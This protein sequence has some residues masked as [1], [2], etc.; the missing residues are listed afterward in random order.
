MKKAISWFE[1]KKKKVMK[2]YF[3]SLTNTYD[4]QG[5]GMEE[6]GWGGRC[7]LTAELS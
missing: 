5:G 4:M 3:G 6:D 7:S 1:M 2:Q